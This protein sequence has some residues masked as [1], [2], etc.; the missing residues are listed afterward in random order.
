VAI[1]NVIGG[2]LIQEQKRKTDFSALNVVCL[3]EKQQ[4]TM[5]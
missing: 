2:V 4:K 3:A 5:L 1:N